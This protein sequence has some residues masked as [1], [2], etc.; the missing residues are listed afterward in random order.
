VNKAAVAQYPKSLAQLPV[1]MPTKHSALRPRI[2]R[3]FEAQG[4]RP[5]IVG[6]FEDSA[7]MAVFAAKGLGVFPV[8]R[9]GAAGVALMRGLRLLGH[10]D[11][12]FEEIHAIRSRR[13]QHHPLVNQ[14]IAAARAGTHAIG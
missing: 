7:L 10:C 14:M 12:V 8:S 5:R 3:W 11:G 2:D 4:L 13:G 9:F 6:E 1:L